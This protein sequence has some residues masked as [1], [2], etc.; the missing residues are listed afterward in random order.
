MLDASRVGML[1]Q[2]P[3]TSPF[4]SVEI[5]FLKRSFRNQKRATRVLNF[6]RFQICKYFHEAGVLGMEATLD[7]Q[8]VAFRAILNQG[9]ISSLNID[10]DKRDKSTC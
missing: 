10:T 6:S 9:D 7:N 5:S 3:T 1:R 2:S 4:L 8:R